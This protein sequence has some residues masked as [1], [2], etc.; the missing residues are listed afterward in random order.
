[1][2][3]GTITGC[4]AANQGG[5]VYMSSGSSFTMDGGTIEQCSSGSGGSVSVN[6]TAVWKLNDGK[7]DDLVA[8]IGDTRYTSL[9]AAID[10]ASDG[11]KENPV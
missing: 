10:A 3:A 5:G 4:T 9:Q 1:M 2:Q 7:V 11:T 8:K 6:G